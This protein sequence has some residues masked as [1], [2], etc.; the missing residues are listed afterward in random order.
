MM[1]GSKTSKL[2]TSSKTRRL[3]SWIPPGLQFAIPPLPAAGGGAQ[4]RITMATHRKKHQVK[5]IHRMQW[6]TLMSLFKDPGDGG[7]KKSIRSH[8]LSQAWPSLRHRV[9]GPCDSAAMV[10][11]LTISRFKSKIL[12]EKGLNMYIGEFSHNMI[13]GAWMVGHECEWLYF[14]EKPEVCLVLHTSGTTKKP[15][16]VPITLANSA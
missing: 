12:S 1:Q 3:V 9:A 5:T 15:K 10:G 7:E 4:E 2:T 14:F 11:G 8:R 6:N 16:I 13:C